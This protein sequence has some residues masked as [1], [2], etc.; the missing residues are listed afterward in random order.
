MTD[1]S[2]LAEQLHNIALRGE[3]PEIDHEDAEKILLAII[4]RLVDRN[5][6]EQ[7]ITEFYRI[8]KWYS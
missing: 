4:S 3:D 8:K 5:S 1:I 6:A 7:V 2:D